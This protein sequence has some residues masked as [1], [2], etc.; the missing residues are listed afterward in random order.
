[1][2]LLSPPQRVIIPRF[3]LLK[4]TR[5]YQ[6]EDDMDL[7]AAFTLYPDLIESGFHKGGVEEQDL[8]IIHCKDEEDRD[9]FIKLTQTSLNLRRGKRII[10][11]ILE[12]TMI[13]IARGIREGKFNSSFRFLL[14]APQFSRKFIW[15][16]Q[17][18]PRNLGLELYY[19]RIARANNGSQFLKEQ[20]SKSARFS[21]IMELEVSLTQKFSFY[22]SEI[23]N[24][25][26]NAIAHLQTTIY[27]MNPIERRII[28]LCFKYGFINESKPP[29]GLPILSLEY[30]GAKQRLQRKGVI[31]QYEDYIVQSYIIGYMRRRKLLVQF[32]D[33]DLEAYIAFY[34]DFGE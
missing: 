22:D 5:K 33:A 12:F 23:D 26:A 3:R 27:F 32:S 21:N 16:L 2:P 31:R 6:I 24:D 34:V 15:K 20:A 17:N 11:E 9:V 18:N 14:V 29:Q 28:A 1:M 19:W 10:R 7:L 30:I 4:A 25:L 13:Q 8:G